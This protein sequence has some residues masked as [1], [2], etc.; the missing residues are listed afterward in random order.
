MSGAIS[1]SIAVTKATKPPTE[2][3]WS[4]LWTSATVITVDKAIAASSC[5][6][7]VMAADAAV[8]FIDSR[9]KPSLR[10]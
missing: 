6:S 4:A 1:I 5:V 9:R 7:G 2:V 3:L 8:D 10:P